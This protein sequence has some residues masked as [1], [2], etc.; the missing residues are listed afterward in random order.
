MDE[1]HF[2]LSVFCANVHRSNPITH[3]ILQTHSAP[4]SD[5][6]VIIITEPWIGTVCAETN[7]KGTVKH[8]DWHCIMP[9]PIHS[10]R[11]ALY[12]KKSAPFRA[13][14]LIHSPFSS[15]NILP[16]RITMDDSFSLL[17]LAVYNSPTSFEASNLL[18][19]CTLPEEPT[20]LCGDFNLHAPDWD[21]TVQVADNH[22]NT[23]QD[24]MMDN[25]FTVL[26]NPD[27]PTYHGHHFEH[28]KVDDLVI[29]NT[30]VYLNYDIT[31]VE[32]HNE[33]HFASDHYPISFTVY[34]Y[35]SPPPTPTKYAFTE[36]NSAKW[37]EIAT[38][39][40]E[41]IL[42]DLP[43]QPTLA[44]LDILAQS[45]MDT[46]TQTTQ[47]SMPICS[48][49]SLHAKHWWNEDLSHTLNE[50]RRLAHGVKDTHQNPYLVQQYQQTKGVFRAKVRHAKRTW[51]TTRLEGATSQ[52]VWEFIKWYKHGGKKCRPLYSTPSHVP[53][54]DDNARAQLF[55]QQF[56]PDPPPVQP[57]TPNDPPQ[58]QRESHLLQRHEIEDAI[59]HC[60]KKTAPGPSNINYMAVKW[61]WNACPN[62]LFY[63]YSGCIQL[64]HYPS[65]FKHS[66]T[67]VV[68]KPNKNNYA[69]P[70]SYRPIQLVECLGKILDKIMARRI[71][72]EVAVH[73][74]IPTTQ[75]GGRIHSSTLDAG[76]S[77]IQDIHDAWARGQKA[78]ALLFDI[79]G[80]FNFV[81]HEGLLAR[82]KHYGFSGN[83][84]AFI[85][86]FLKDRTTAFSFDGFISSVL[87]ILNG[88][89]Q[90]SPL[91]PILAILYGAD[92]QK[93][94]EL[95][96]RR[97]VSFAYVDDGALLTFS[98]TL[99]INI[100]K[101]Q[102]AFGAVSQWLNANGLEVQPAKLEL[103]HF[104]KSNDP[105][106]PPFHWPGLQ[107]PIVAHKTIRW[108]GFFLDRH[109]NFV[110][111]TK[112]MAARASATIRAMGILGNTV[113]GMSHVQLR[114]LTISTIIP[115]LTYGCQLWWGG[116][117][118][119]SNSGRLQKTLNGAL[120]LVCRA[121]RTTSIPAL[122]YISHIP[123]IC[124]TIKRLCY[125]T[126]LR[127]HRLLP[128]S[129][130]LQ[131]IP[132]PSHPQIHL[133]HQ[134]SHTINILQ[135][136]SSR[137]S[138]LERI[139]QLANA[140]PTPSLNPLHDPPWT[141]LFSN[142]PQV[143]L[144]L[145]PPKDMREQY[146]TNM[147]DILRN[148]LDKDNIL[149]IG[150]DGSRRK[151][152]GSRRTGA[153]VFIRHGHTIVSEH[154]YGI[155][156]KSN[157]YDGE[158]LALMAGMRLAVQYCSNHPQISTIH[159]FSDSASALSNIV[160]SHA[161]PSQIISLLFIKYA[162]QF[163]ESIDHHIVLQWVPG[164]QGYDVNIRAD[165]LAR[166]GCR[167]DQEILPNTLSYHA[168]QKSQLV[169][170]HW[171]RELRSKPLTGAF[172]AVTNDPPHIKPSKVFLQLQNQPE[173]FGRLTQARTMHGYNPHY[174]ARFALDGDPLC[175]CGHLVPPF[176]PQRFRDHVLHNCEAY[177]NHRHVLTAVSRDHHAPILLGS[178]KGLLAT[179]KFLCESGAFT[180]TGQPYLPPNTPNLP[181]LAL[182]LHDPP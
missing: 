152:V 37:A 41:R 137:K 115:V 177:N 1:N 141:Q 144:N 13:A 82:F 4:S 114:Q 112:I 88:V 91:S 103:M 166:Q 34:T 134:H 128:N 124:H 133:A 164:H 158:S 165:K 113:Q 110:E 7:E 60:H 50:L 51:A 146:K 145:P 62:L 75:F 122:Q 67:A 8:P 74:V 105:T 59:A 35:T 170:K 16:V 150:T 100:T 156:Q 61:T 19:G 180:S 175:V 123:P 18:Q 68:P 38:P 86:S 32:V 11:V 173:V 104:T 55:A 97:I 129:P 120:R 79:S 102:A 140:T 92:L 42:D 99:A 31:P 168:E 80:F 143:S 58:Q 73:D 43:P 106:S 136:P 111:H 87:P 30:E 40:F 78:S 135:T 54:E 147:T 171:R 94:R 17:L 48:T 85:R 161:H 10:A 9:S 153:G 142:H 148:S 52:N 77:F 117:Y 98:S 151:V 126:S 116:R 162:L 167:L 83:T 130:V 64:G 84:I 56:F 155:G 28:Q 65:P 72:Y 95:I 3:T 108:L 45:I 5:I 44:S 89:P 176:P 23:F 127:M 25:S 46:I 121:F 14:P 159:F 24:W 139:A 181:G 47:H 174:Y 76:L 132:T 66:I 109:L 57:Y 178:P 93:L 149:V 12:H 71:Q 182:V 118:S 154:S 70:A 81:N 20:I 157:V 49:P 2:S 63:L 33:E 96:L 169:Q 15:R 53:A 101:L 22:A 119:S 26:N 125:S 6:S 21:S 131:R 39:L 160:C 69:N 90:G 179:A 163:L 36:K 27:L 107:A 29:A 172:G 138:P